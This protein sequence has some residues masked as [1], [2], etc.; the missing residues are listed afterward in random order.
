MPDLVALDFDGVI[1]DGLR[2]YF[3]TVALVYEEI[4]GAAD[5]EPY[6]QAFYRLRPVVE[7][8]WEMPLV[9]RSLVLGQSESKILSHWPSLV[10]E[11]VTREGLEAKALGAQVDGM[12]DRRIEA[13]LDGWLAEHRFYPEMLGALGAMGSFVIISTKEGRFIQKLL[14]RQGIEIEDERIYGK[15]RG[16]SKPDVLLEMRR[17]FE[18]IW[19]VEDRLQT[20]HKVQQCAGLEDVRLFLADWG[21]NL[22]AE[23]SA[24]RE[25]GIVLLS[26]ARVGLGLG[27]WVEG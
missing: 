10:A 9:L 22:A 5:L 15:E 1:C 24:A 18:Q 25:G 2:E 4:W 14:G 3:Q 12:R 11:L 8:G 16:R 26:G 7:T 23:R 13:D 17:S 21:Y 20:L 19:F 27:A 6:R